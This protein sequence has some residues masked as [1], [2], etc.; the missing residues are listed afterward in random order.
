MESM[1]SSETMVKLADLNKAEVRKLIPTIVYM[2]TIAVFGIVGN[3]LVIHI[4]RTRYKQS[5]SKSFILCLSAVDLFTCCASIPLE[6]STIFEQFMFKHLWLCKLSRSFNT[7]GTCASAF[8]LLFIAV[9][10]Y[11]KVCRPFAKQIR[12]T[13]AKFLC[14]LSIILAAL[15]SLPAVFIYGKHTFDIPEFNITG[16]ECST[17]DAM[18]GEPFPFINSLMFGV[19]FITEIMCMSVLYCFIGHEVKKHARKMHKMSISMER[20]PASSVVDAIDSRMSGE[21]IPDTKT[22][23]NMANSKNKELKRKRNESLNA[24][25]EDSW[26]DKREFELSTASKDY[27]E[28]FKVNQTARKPKQESCADNKNADD[29]DQNF[30]SDDSGIKVKDDTEQDGDQTVNTESNGE[31]VNTTTDQPDAEQ[32]DQKP[33]ITLNINAIVV[34]NDSE[35]SG[36]HINESPVFYETLK[37]TENVEGQC[38][39]GEKRE[40]SLS[41]FGR[42]ISEAV[43]RLASIVSTTTDNNEKTIKRTQFLK[44]ARARK[45]ALLMFVITVAFVISFLPHLILMILRQVKSNFVENLSEDNIAVYKFFLRSYFLNCAINP[46]IYSVCDSRFRACCKSLVLSWCRCF[47]K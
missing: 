4:Y 8:I 17:S 26:T 37:D 5:N 42:R 40:G 47:H 25:S 14:L 16:T 11:R 34:A 2:L 28:Q 31:I 41:Y 35:I 24:F 39:K 46:I 22:K 6:V 27:N 18:K 10:R 43:S 3:S 7:F 32:S 15:M 33:N 44:Q 36:E 9:D 21:I 1:N 38:E 30:D 13:I 45:T 23:Y 19:L 12:N 29:C 20:A